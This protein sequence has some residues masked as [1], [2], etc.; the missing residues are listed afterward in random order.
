MGGSARQPFQMKLLWWRKTKRT[1]K[2]FNITEAGVYQQQLVNLVKVLQEKLI[3]EKR[4]MQTLEVTIREEVCREMAEQLVSIEKAYSE[5]V[6]MEVNAVEEKC[7]RRIELLTQSIKKTRKRARI[8]RIEED[9]EEWVPSVFLHAEQT[10]VRVSE[11]ETKTTLI[12]EQNATIAELRQEVKQLKESREEETAKSEVVLELQGH[13]ND[14]NEE[15]TE[16]KQMLEEAGEAFTEKEAE[17]SKLRAALDD[18]E[19]CIRKQDAALKHLTTELEKE[20]ATPKAMA[21][22]DELSR[23]K[24]ALDATMAKLADTEKHL[25]TKDSMMKE[26]VRT[27]EETRDELA[28]ERSYVAQAFDNDEELIR[29]KEELQKAEAQT[30]ELAENV[31]PKMKPLPLWSR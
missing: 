15:V 29:I 11:L 3:E 17:I 26:L 8:E 24:G 14:A 20:K 12:S 7:D 10:K 22:A 4:K 27:L 30:K 9:D 19:A 5:R 6:K 16:L 25:E 1:K 31:P 21:D 13:L 28:R 2:K 18:E 23:L